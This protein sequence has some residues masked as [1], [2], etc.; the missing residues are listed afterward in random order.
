MMSTRWSQTITMRQ[1]KHRR[2]PAPSPPED[3]REYLFSYI[4][5]IRSL[6]MY[7]GADTHTHTDMHVNSSYLHFLFSCITFH[8][9]LHCVFVC[10]TQHEE[11]LFYASHSRPAV[12]TLARIVIMTHRVC[13]DT[14]DLSKIKHLPVV[15]F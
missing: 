1:P 11:I 9:Y 2:D 5:H 12:S 13:G 10:A 15:A 7:V 14:A 4:A 3:E 6:I 8:K